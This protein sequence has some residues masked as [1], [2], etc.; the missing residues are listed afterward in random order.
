MDALAAGVPQ[1]RLYNVRSTDAEVAAYESIDLTAY[2]HPS[3]NFE[4]INFHDKSSK[5]K[6]FVMVQ[7]DFPS[8]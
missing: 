4:L 3:T 6:K 2:F 5:R 7:Y 1:G 8:C